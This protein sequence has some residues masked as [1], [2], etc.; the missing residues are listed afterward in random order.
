MSHLFHIIEDAH[1]ILRA[2]NGTFRQVKVFRRGDELF[3]GYGAG[4]VRLYHKAGT[5]A[6]AIFLDTLVLPDGMEAA[7]DGYGRLALVER[8][9]LRV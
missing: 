8:K 4:F 9:V 2:K 7:A 3:A 5:S 1:A 6:P